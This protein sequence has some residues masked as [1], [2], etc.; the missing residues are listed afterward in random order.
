[1][2]EKTLVKPMDKQTFDKL[3]TMYYDL[4]DIHMAYFEIIDSD[5]YSDFTPA[6]DVAMGAVDYAMAALS[7]IM[8]PTGGE[9]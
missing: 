5:D 3:T 7:L 1:M 9:G 4:Q 6:I 8:D 2:T